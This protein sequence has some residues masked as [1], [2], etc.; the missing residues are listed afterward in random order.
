LFKIIKIILRKIFCDFGDPFVIFDA[1]GQASKCSLISF[2]SNESNG[3]VTVLDEHRHDLEDGA[4]VTF[5]EV[6]GMSELNG[7]EFQI[8][9]LGLFVLR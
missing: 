6:K 5:Q 1:D 2:I 3:I 8:K 7:K 4:F 9:V